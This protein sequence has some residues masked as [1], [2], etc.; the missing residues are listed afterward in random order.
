MKIGPKHL[1]AV[2]LLLIAG[3]LACQAMR[4]SGGTGQPGTTETYYT[5]PS[6]GTPV[7]PA[8]TQVTPVMYTQHRYPDHAGGEV[9][10][11]LHWGHSIATIPRGPDSLW[12]V[13]PPSEENL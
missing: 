4:K 6:F 2:A 10:A 12:M 5:V 9:S 13:R 7:V 8:W 1:L 11:L 3:C